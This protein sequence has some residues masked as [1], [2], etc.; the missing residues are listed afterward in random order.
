MKQI[1]LL[2]SLLLLLLATACEEEERAFPE[3]GDDDVGTGA[4]PR[5][6]GDVEGIYNFFDIENSEISFDVEFYDVNQG[7]DVAEYNWTATYRNKQSDE[8]IGPA[9]VLSIPASEFG[10]SESGLPSARVTLN[11]PMVLEALSV[12]PDSVNGGDD[13]RFE[14]TIVLNDGRTFTRSNTGANVIS[15]GSF[16]GAFIL[17]QPIICPSDIGGTYAYSTVIT[18]EWPEGCAVGTTAEGTVT[19]TET[20]EGLYEI[21]DFSFGGYGACYGSGTPGGTLRFQDACNNISTTGVDS[22]GDSYTISNLSVDGSNLTFTYASDYGE[23][24]TVTIV[25]PDGWPDFR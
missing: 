17:D 4:F 23:V 6:I 13:L 8:N 19:L 11:L 15:G 22:F 5:Q 10:L 16:R 7:R 20:T 18:T 24:G 3:F 2:P 1:L 9:N 14:S 12:D 21:D 25:N